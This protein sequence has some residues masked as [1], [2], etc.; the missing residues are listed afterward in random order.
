MFDRR[1]ILAGATASLA[2]S[3]RLAGQTLPPQ[4]FATP[5][6]TSPFA[7]D[8]FRE[9]RRRVMEVLK[10]GV[11]VVYGAGPV[12]SAAAVAPPFV[13]DGDFAWLTGIVDEPGAVLVMAPAE[14]TVRE[15]LLLP[16]R[17]QEAE[18]WEVERL[19]LGTELERRT[20]FARVARSAGLGSLVTTLAERSKTLHFLGPIVSASAPVPQ[21][22]EL[23]GK[24]MQRVPGV[25]IK[26]ES[27]LLPSLRIV[28]EPR[29]LELIR[30][31]TT[32]TAR[33]HIAAMKQARPGMTER[34]L[35]AIL[36]DGFRA[37]GG[38][39]LAYDSI[40]ATGRNAASL[41]YTGGGGVIG[42]N[43]LILIDAAASVGGY[44]CDVT[45]TFPASGRFTPEQ[46]ASYELVLAAQTAA[47]ARLKAGV[48]YEDLVE[49]AKDVFRKAGRVDDFTHGLGHLVGL[50]VHDVGDMSKPLPA[51]AVITVEPG[52]YVQSDNYGI[53][54]EDL[55]LITQNGSQRL[56][57]GVPRTVEEIEAAMGR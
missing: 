30:K 24:V 23:Y 53:R 28:K 8:I 4:G 3:T 41:H 36:E 1:T 48:Y 29:E 12:E 10:D 49:A 18:R 55:Y 20:G 9:R 57:E 50:D 17:D 47:V 40:V 34:Q 16:S 56:S 15:W 22:L 43:D 7:P 33:G 26:D 45:R 14:R 38:E 27:G 25:S 44:A 54:I 42:S 52:L 11:T 32:A 39:G 37:G 19:P 51:G 46:R 31:A 35:K 21:A 6:G 2:F 13:Q 5:A